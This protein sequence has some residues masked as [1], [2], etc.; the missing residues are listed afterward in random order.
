MPTLPQ[1]LSLSSARTSPF[2]TQFFLIFTRLLTR[3]CYFDAFSSSPVV[4]ISLLPLL[5]L[6]LLICPFFLKDR[7]VKQS[8][9]SENT[10][11]R[12]RFYLPLYLCCF[13]LH[14]L[15]HCFSS[16]SFRLPGAFLR[17]SSTIHSLPY[18]L[19]KPQSS[20]CCGYTQ[21]RIFFMC[22]VFGSAE[23]F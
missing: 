10:L 21:Q 19:N 6:L 17:D 8:A 13:L 4:S 3:F 23:K 20:K 7:P 18:A 12:F 22:T 11:F 9:V 1:A 15:L 14:R 5:L 16:P 2:I